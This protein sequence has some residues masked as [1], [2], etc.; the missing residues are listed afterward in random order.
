MSEE[1]V[2]TK[3]LRMTKKYGC[4]QK[5]KVLFVGPKFENP[6]T[7]GT[8][9]LSEV[10]QYFAA[11]NVE[12]RFLGLPWFCRLG[13]RGSL[14]TNLWCMK[15]FLK[16]DRKQDYILIEDYGL[17][18][19]NMLL[20][21]Y[22]VRAICKNKLV[23]VVQA[24]YLS[25]RKSIVKN[26]LDRWV[27][28]LFLKQADLV[29]GGGGYAIANRIRKM[30]VSAQRI[31]S[32]NPG[33]D[34]GFIESKPIM[35]REVTNRELNLL[36]V[37]RFHPNKGLE[38]LAEA[39]RLIRHEPWQLT[40]VGDTSYDLDYGKKIMN[41]IKELGISDRIV[42]QGRIT[43]IGEL[44][45]MYE[46]ADIFVLPSVEECYPFVLLEAMSVG[47]PIVATDVAAIPEIVKDGVQGIIVPSKNPQALANA[48][49]KLIHDSPLRESMSRNSLKRS[50]QLIRKWHQVGEEFYE[51]LLE[52]LATV[53]KKR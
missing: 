19:Y 47:L 52:M 42:Y 37:G 18:C 38:Y 29:I 26:T 20:F 9:Y 10:L 48:I 49:R 13:W 50:T 6:K 46:E 2:E 45:K 15:Q 36:F 32:I 3:W 23:I 41:K 8:R 53:G 22:L 35:P 17:R 43:D 11:R 16:V 7:G 33:I 30:N 27:S 51:T 25:S 12:V 31:R 5:M 14:L 21:N 44:R 40:I 4:Y 28:T 24:F 34:A 39:L 1:Y